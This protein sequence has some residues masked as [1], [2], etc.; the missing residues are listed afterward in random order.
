MAIFF[1]DYL[2]ERVIS[3]TPE[4]LTALGISALLLDMDNTL[5]THD[6][7]VPYEGV[8]E[9]LESLKKAG[10]QLV[11]VSNNHPERVE[12]FARLL[13][14][15]YVADGAKPLPTGYRRAVE[16]LGMTL[17]K[18]KAAAV[19][20]QNFTDIIGGNLL[21]VTTIMVTEITPEQGWFFRLKRWLERL[22]MTEKRVK[23]IGH[24]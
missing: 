15:P 23:R 6:N 5:T 11:I 14:L 22:L 3:L 17:E 19:G 24:I 10:F 12:P 21:G 2:T 18:K 1:P 13:G 7:P 8:L 9:W 4:K 16:L 20:D